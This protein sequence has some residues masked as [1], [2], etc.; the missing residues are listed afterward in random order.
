MRRKGI[1]KSKKDEK[2]NETKIFKQQ[3]KNYSR[4]CELKWDFN[5]K[6]LIE[7]LP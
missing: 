5:A 7:R 6:L 2:L 1:F 3:S 4:Q